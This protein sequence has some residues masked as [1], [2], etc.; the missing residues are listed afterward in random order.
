MLTFNEP[1]HEYFWNGRQVVNVTRVLAPLIDLSR[2]QADVLENARQEGKAIHRMAELE[3]KGDLNESNL[4]AWLQPYLQAWRKFMTDS[5]FE[6]WSSERRL[7]NKRY[8]YAGTPDLVG[9]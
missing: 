6:M 4:P 2:I 7:Y 9:I 3:C 8:A 1:S 5:G